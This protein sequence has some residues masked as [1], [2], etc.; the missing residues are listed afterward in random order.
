MLNKRRG[1][2]ANRTS[3]SKGE[4]MLNRQT[5]KGMFLEQIVL[6]IDILKGL[7][8]RPSSTRFK[9]HRQINNPWPIES[10]KIVGGRIVQGVG[11]EAQD[12]MYGP[13]TQIDNILGRRGKLT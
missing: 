11:R 10:H 8:G 4:V 3:G 1:V 5:V 9:K 2:P 12:L 6:K 7:V 13:P